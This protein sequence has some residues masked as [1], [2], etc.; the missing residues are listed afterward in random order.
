MR[1]FAIYLPGRKDLAIKEYYESKPEALAI[2]KSHKEARLK[3]FA[4]AQDA[5]DFHH[6]GDA[7]T[8]VNE[9]G[10]PKSET[11]AVQRIMKPAFPGPTSQK[12]VEF[13][14]YIEANNLAM[15]KSLIDQNPR[16]LISS[17]DTPTVLKE[18]A[19]YNALHVVAMHD[20]GEMCRMILQT[21]EQSDYIV[22]LHGQRTPST[23][24]VCDILLDMYLNTPDK[25]RGETPLHFAAK[26]GSVS[27]V[28]ELIVYPQCKPSKNKD[29][30]LPKDIICS[31][32]NSVKNTA[33]IAHTIRNLLEER[34]FVPV[35]RS[36]DAC[37]QPIVGEPISSTGI[38]VLL[39]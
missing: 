7:N 10:T 1:Y 34:F 14:K 15:V 12:L 24:E 39:P 23:T 33:E 30:L 5:R 11:V 25:S 35:W 21:I 19:R 28:K 17:G 9:T 27:V 26:Y 36:D 2:L 4:T 18:G 8:T 29:G 32:A 16:F 3:E 31:R 6:N 22:L 38:V 13:R 20:H 37:M